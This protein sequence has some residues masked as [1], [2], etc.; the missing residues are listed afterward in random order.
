VPECS[1]CGAEIPEGSRFCLECGRPLREAESA[2]PRRRLG[3][4]GDFPALAPL[5]V[6]AIALAVGAV[7]LLAGGVWAWGVV[8]LL[9]AAVLVLL[10]G[11][12]DRARVDDLRF[13]AGAARESLAVKGRGQVEV[14]RARRE[15][16][17]LE[18]D[19]ARL[20][21]ELG[22]AVYEEDKAGTEAA[23]TA[24][25]AVVG[26]IEAKE[27]EIQTLIRETEE[28]VRLVQGPVQPTEILKD[29]APPEPPR[30]PEPWP[31]PDEGDIPE[32]PQP[33]PGD[34]TPGPDEPAPPARPPAPGSSRK[35][36]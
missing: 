24:L 1:S 27:A 25:R 17:E 9:G 18:A 11:R 13:R 19:R 36:A 12:V 10:P 29:E 34:P 35:S 15:L 14:F 26:R 7:I 3:L 30:I 33:G 6:A 31:P 4:P 28:R 16:A 5:S 21:A 32:P 8:A 2:R 22:R 20:Y 23:R